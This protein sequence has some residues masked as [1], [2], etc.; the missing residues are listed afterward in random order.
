M[1]YFGTDTHYHVRL[2]NNSE[3]IVRQQN[4]HGGNDTFEAGNKV[5]V[6]FDD[7]AARVLKD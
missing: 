1:V 6:T 7:G 5:G 3:F 2:K 4:S